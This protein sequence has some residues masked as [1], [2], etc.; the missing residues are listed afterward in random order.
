MCVIIC[1]TVYFP[2]V[3]TYFVY[4]DEYLLTLDRD[5]TN[6]PR[7]S[8]NPVPNDL[9]NYR[10]NLVFSEMLTT[11]SSVPIAERSRAGV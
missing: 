3:C 11:K 7:T 4:L 6:P 8:E 2:E 5:I 1:Y 10:L 9:W